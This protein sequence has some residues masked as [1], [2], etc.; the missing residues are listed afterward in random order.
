MSLV[1]TTLEAEDGRV[2][3]LL[4]EI[5][6]ATT[7]GV[8]VGVMVSSSSVEVEVGGRVGAAAVVVEIADGVVV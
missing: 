6:L 5:G 3:L 1:D 7:G 4:D 8:V 2:T